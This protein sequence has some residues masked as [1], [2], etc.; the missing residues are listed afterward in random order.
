MWRTSLCPLFDV[1]DGGGDAAGQPQ[2]SSPHVWC[3]KWLWV[4]VRSC[5]RWH[6]VCRFRDWAGGDANGSL[7]VDRVSGSQL[8]VAGNV[9]SGREEPTSSLYGDQRVRSPSP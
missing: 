7:D 4:I 3:E 1:V 9:L 2:T 6:G 8:D 5:A